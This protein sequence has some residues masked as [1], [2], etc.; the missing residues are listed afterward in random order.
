MLNKFGK[1][2]IGYWILFGY[3]LLM[4][5]V[6]PLFAQTNNG[7][8]FSLDANSAT[9]PLPKIFKPNI[10]L[11]GRGF[12]RENDW[13]QTLAAKEALDTWQKEIGFNGV[14][15]LQYNLWEINERAKEKEAKDALLRNYEDIIKRISDA[16]GIIILDIFGTPA[17]LGKVL[18]KR[19]MPVDLKAYKEL[20]KG[21][22]RGLSCE[23]RYNIWYEA[24]SAPDLDDFFL[25]RTQEYLNL[26]RAI[27]ESAK[28]L[29]AETKV[30]IPV[31]GPGVS[32]WFQGVDGNTTF[33]PERSLIYDLIKF[34]SRYKLPLDFISWHAYS[35]DPKVERENS[36]Y[37]NTALVLIR[38]WLTY[39]NFERETPLIITEWNYDSSANILPARGER[40]YIG[41]SFIPSRIINMHKTGLNYQLYFCLEDFQNIKE[42]VVRNVGIFSFDPESSRYKGAPKGAY[43]IFRMLAGLGNKI[44]EPQPK[45]D[46]KF[47]EVLATK[48]E[49]Y[50]SILISNYIDPYIAT[51]FL[52]Q[53]ISGLNKA[54]RQFI[55][56]FVS[57]DKLDKF[58]RRQLDA[59]KLRTTKKVK[60]LLKKTQELNDE[61]VKFRDLSRNIKVEIKNLKGQYLYQR[62]T[63][64]SNYIQ[65]SGFN[66]AE[67]KEINVSDIYQETLSLPPYSV[68]MIIIKNKPPEPQ[69]Q[70]Q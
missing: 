36:I 52:S 37:N 54:E 16:G 61:A 20:V 50:I 40:F 18:D 29:E 65:G 60:S 28:E 26:Y 38:D 31:G 45:L 57:S 55:L 48:A 49:D 10:D 62:Y 24:W 68:N 67:E 27:A 33:T 5:G 51:S 56:S 30:H 64:D 8:E 66:I 21:Y 3:W 35:T 32:W 9:V 53:N 46:D 11:S 39:F 34:C 58:L 6:S 22:I 70:S 59:T 13:P 63:V 43:N 7:L 69:T 15:R 41:A 12:H 44:F 42:G 14:Y 25:G 47:V 1:L 23:K 4:F 2:V 19:C 17:G